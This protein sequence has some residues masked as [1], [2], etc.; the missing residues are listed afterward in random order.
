MDYQRWKILGVPV[1]NGEKIT[2]YHSTYQIVGGPFPS[3]NFEA[4]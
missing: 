1:L 3:N 2:N 4:V